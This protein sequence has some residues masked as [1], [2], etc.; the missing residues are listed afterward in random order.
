MRRIG[1]PGLERKANQLVRRA[2]ELAREAREQA[3]KASDSVAIAGVISPLEHCFRPDLTPPLDQCR[4]EHRE[5]VEEMKAAGV[6][7]ILLESMNGV[8]E[9]QVAC[10]V[11][12]S[13]GLSFWGSFVVRE[14]RRLLRKE[15]LVETVKA[16]LALGAVVVVVYCAPLVEVTGVS[17]ATP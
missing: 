9:G 5:I 7:F 2:V 17:S 3:G 6:D 10:E 4:T 14:D 8:A 15:P 16:V 13:S 12:R 11:A 1:P